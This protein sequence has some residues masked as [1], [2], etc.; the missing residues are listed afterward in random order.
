MGSLQS[1]QL[2]RIGMVYLEE[3]ILEVL[4]EPA[5][6]E[7][8]RTPGEIS[9][10]LG[11]PRSEEARNYPIVYG[12]LCKLAEVDGRV[13]RCPNRKGR[14]RMTMEEFSNWK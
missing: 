13:E 4:L 8:G 2:A 14:W 5:M 12:I 9:R 10:E 1:R 3:A 11:V 6:I 7:D